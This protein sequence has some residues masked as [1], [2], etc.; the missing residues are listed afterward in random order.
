[1]ATPWPADRALDPE[2]LTG[3][4]LADEAIAAPG[5]IPE[6]APARRGFGVVFWIATAW[7]VLVILAAVFASVLPLESPTAVD[8]THRLEAIG[9]SGHLLGTD[10]LGRDLLSRLVYGARVS[11]TVGAAAVAIGLTIGGILGMIA[12]FRRGGIERLIMWVS[13]V[14]LSFPALVLLIS[15]VAFAGHSLRTI[16]LVLG[17]ISI[18]VYARLARAH[19]LAIGGRDFVLAARAIGLT[20]LRIIRREIMPN[21]LPPVVSYGLI[22]VGVVIVVEGSLSFLGLSVSAP[23]PSWGG[24]IADG[25]TFLSQDPAL[26][27]VPSAVMCITVLALNL[28]GDTLRRRHESAGRA[29]L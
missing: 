9:S 2:A 20:R 15:V 6:A 13:D 22:A 3:I 26:V 16:S 11:L 12:G 10:T 23:T 8:P 29:S 4:G 18:P 17:F 19:T 25:Q 28:V 27:L 1:M 5:A 7:I 14:I 24:L 21:V